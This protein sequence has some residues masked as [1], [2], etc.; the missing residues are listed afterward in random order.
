MR[1]TLQPKAERGVRWNLIHR[2]ETLLCHLEKN[3]TV[4]SAAINAVALFFFS[5]KM[6]NSEVHKK[7]KESFLINIVSETCF[8]STARVHASTD[9][10]RCQVCWKFGP[11]GLHIWVTD[12]HLYPWQFVISTDANFRLAVWKKEVVI[13]SAILFY[14]LWCESTPGS[15]N[16]WKLVKKWV[17]CRR[18]D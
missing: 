13:S 3:T 7:F 4:S 2:F 8:Q 9:L 6:W 10:R 12:I 14:D 15:V 5:S 1:V 11:Y 16:I 18:S 17:V